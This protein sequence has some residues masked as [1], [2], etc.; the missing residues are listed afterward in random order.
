MRENINLRQKTVEKCFETVFIWGGYN[1]TSSLALRQA[2]F[3]LLR[4]ASADA[5]SSSTPAPIAYAGVNKGYKVIS[6]GE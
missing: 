5:L 3:Y 4:K 6:A 1:H 2:K